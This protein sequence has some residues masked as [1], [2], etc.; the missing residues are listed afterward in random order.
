[1]RLLE[2][3]H[4]RKLVEHSCVTQT[5]D[6]SAFID[7]FAIGIWQGRR[8]VRL[9]NQPF[10]GRAAALT[11]YTRLNRRCSCARLLELICSSTFRVEATTFISMIY[12]IAAPPR[13]NLFRFHFGRRRTTLI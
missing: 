7:E 4:G 2:L 10:P 13:E 3:P 6:A 1:M 9:A 5:R 8:G 11:G 12:L